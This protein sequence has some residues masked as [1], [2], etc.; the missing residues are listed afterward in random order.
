MKQLEN[1]EKW[2]AEYLPEVLDDLNPGAG[3]GEIKGLEDAIQVQLPDAFKELYLW[4]NGQKMNLRTGPWY[5]LSFMSL[6]LIKKEYEMWTQ[7][8]RDSSP[9]SMK[10]LAESMRSTPP[11][12]VKCEYVNLKWIP[13]GYDWGG[14]YLGID[15]DPDVLGNAGQVINF[16]RD[17]ERKIAVAPNLENYLDW[18]LNELDSGNFNIKTEAD[19]GRSF[20]TLNPPKM[21]FLDSLASI[22]PDKN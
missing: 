7:V 1:F 10:D 17:E 16:G 20:N 18:M 3:E 19:G 12:F 6:D 2:L 11:Q 4:H 14:N 5:G 15:L 21:H 9:D 22:F 8:K 13:F